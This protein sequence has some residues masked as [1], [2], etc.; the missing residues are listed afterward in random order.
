MM[1]SMRVSVKATVGLRAT[2]LATVL[3][4][5]CALPAASA[6]AQPG[7]CPAVPT[8]MF[9][10]SAPIDVPV[11]A[12]GA[13]VPSL[14]VDCDGAPLA[15]ADVG[16]T[17]VPGKTDVS[18]GQLGV[19]EE[20]VVTNAQGVVAPVVVTS[21]LTTGTFS[22]GVEVDG[23][24]ESLPGEVV[25]QLRGMLPPHYPAY[26]LSIDEH[27]Q[28]DCTGVHDHSPVCLDESVALLNSGRRSEHLGPLVL[29]AN[30]RRLTVPQQ[31]F[32]MTDLERTARGLPPDSGLAR[33]WDAAA[34]AGAAAGTDP[35]T[36]GSGA[37]GFESI[38]AGGMPN[39]IIAML[40]LIY[41]DAFYRDGASQ[42]IDCTQT[43]KTGCW[44]H[45][46]AELHDTSQFSCETL[47]A[48]GAGYSPK[49]FDGH[50]SY[51][52]VFGA[53]GGDNQDPLTFLWLA[54]VRQLPACERSGDTCGWKNRP[55]LT[56]KGFTHI[57]GFARG[58]SPPIRPWFH[59]GV[60]GHVNGDG[61][62]NL[63][64]VVSQHLAGITALAN[65]GREHRRLHVKRVSAYSFT[66]VGTL[67][68]GRWTI[69]IR[70]GTPRAYGADPSSLLHV[71]VRRPL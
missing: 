10:S 8:L 63:S 21:A 51:A 46:G 9:A 39:P 12:G 22:L 56:A 58:E 47:C 41:N 19:A 59:V 42:N 34:T 64:V 44:G 18:F 5:A 35:T 37:H 55:L 54:E 70:Y 50:E 62:V 7:S 3:A 69:T 29:P 24:T 61:L 40:G 53:Y 45:R 43:N 68:P 1:S 33:D 48:M 28:P 27:T 30:W 57:R 15:N 25:G 71:T 14:T 60:G 38:W 16:L 52:E 26:G 4:A 31:M 32:V 17:L 65:R 20:E 66:V 13:Y 6:S 11:G 67:P 2:V 23:A 36:A 49:A